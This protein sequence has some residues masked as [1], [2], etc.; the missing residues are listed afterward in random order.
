MKKKLQNIKRR[1]FLKKSTQAGAALFSLSGCAGINSYFQAD[2]VLYDKEVFIIGAGAAGLMSAHTL[3]KNRI[4]FRLFE[5]SSRPGGRLFSVQVDGNTSL[6]LGAEFF[7]AH[8]RIVFELLKEFQLE[9]EEQIWD[10]ISRPIWQSSAG[11]VLSEIEYQRVS[12]SLISRLISDRLKVFGSS[13]NY[14]V[15]SP[16]LATELDN[17]SFYDYMQSHW[18]SPDERVLQFWDIQNRSQFSADSKSISALQV[19]WHQPQDQKIKS[20]F[21]VQGGWSR[22]VSRMYERVAGVIPDHLVKLNW[23]LHSIV[24][25]SDDFR[26]QFKS[27]TGLQTLHA[28]NVIIATPI[29][30]LQKISGIFDLD[31]SESKKDRIRTARLGESSKAYTKISNQVIS[32][33]GLPAMWYQDQTQY[34]WI[35]SQNQTWLG[36]LRGGD[37]YKWSVPD[38]ENW[39]ASFVEKNQIEKT[40]LSRSSDYHVMNWK[41]QPTI[42]G[43]RSLWE[44]GSWLSK[45][46]VFESSDYSGRLQWAGEYVYSNEKGTVRSAL[47]SGKRAAQEMMKIL[48]PKKNEII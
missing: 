34:Q 3:K 22:L 9:W 18:I 1:D 30:Q 26:F 11:E 15:L 4:P 7:E 32:S 43:A 31:I 16:A 35:K 41:D 24:K 29:N 36:G 48:N 45:S 14:Q 39:K 44:P 5:A 40:L 17:L 33:T 6:E 27:P 8:H 37:S 42:Q 25:T 19:L 46:T 23:S 20:L 47:E 10:P 38:I 2:R 13:S 12:Q 28:Q 21:R